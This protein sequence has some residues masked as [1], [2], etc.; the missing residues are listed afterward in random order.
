ME[1]AILSAM[2]DKAKTARS[3]AMNI[4][5]PGKDQSPSPLDD[6]CL[7]NKPPT[8]LLKFLLVSTINPD[9]STV[10]D[11]QLLEEVMAHPAWARDTLWSPPK[12]KKG[13]DLGFS[14]IVV[15]SV[16]DDLQGTVGKSLMCTTVHFSSCGG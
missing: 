4:D 10:S 2:I 1:Q 9:G 12:F 16:E 8:T 7:L 6:I 13:Q 15:V 3:K 11:D 14:H 5:Q